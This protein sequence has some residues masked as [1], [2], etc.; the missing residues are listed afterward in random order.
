VAQAGSD[1]ANGQGDGKPVT[2]VTIETA[3][4]G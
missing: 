4:A 2:P 3:T 1:N